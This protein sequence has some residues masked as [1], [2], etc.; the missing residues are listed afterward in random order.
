VNDPTFDGE[1]HC[2]QA[3]FLFSRRPASIPC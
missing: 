2:M 3:D 1:G